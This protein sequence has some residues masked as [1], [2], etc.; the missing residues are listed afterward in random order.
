MYGLGTI[1]PRLF[2][3][4]LVPLHT[5]IFAPEA[6]GV[7]TYLYAFVAF[8]NMVYMWGMET[9]FFRFAT[10]PGADATRIFQLAQTVV[11][12]IS[13]TLSVSL[14]L[15]RN[16]LAELLPLEGHSEYVTWLAAVM[17]MDAVVAI[18]FA[19][20]RLEKK[21]IRFAVAK[22]VNVLLLL[23]FNYYL[24]VFR[25]KPADVGYVFLA[26]A[27]A[28]AV[29]L[30]FFGGTLLSWR[31]AFDRQITPAMFSYAYPVMLTGVAG[32]VN[33]MFSRLTLEWWL[34]DNFYEGQTPAYA[35]GVF[36]A[37]YK[38]AVFM[39]LAV[40]AFRFAAEPFFFSNASNKQ[41]PVLF[42]RVNHFFVI[43]CCII[44]VAVSLNLHILKHILG[45]E[46]YWS[47]L[48]IVPILLIAYLF[49]G[50]YYNFSVWFKL[51]DKTH[52]GTWI[53]LG[54]AGLT[55]VLNYL[56]IPHWG[57]VGSSWAALGCYG[58]MM[59]TCYFF[60]Q[61]YFPIPYR[62]PRSLLYL[63]SAV[64]LILVVPLIPLP[65]GW[66]TTTFP[67]LASLLYVGV[68]YA[69]ERKNLLAASIG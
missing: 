4:L 27:L 57:Y 28:N 14:I 52:F 22:V 44:L 24:L 64:G 18:P 53:T 38:Y 5:K 60:G 17:C 36:G 58:G 49:L 62:I 37:C 66:V 68:I 54:G 10:K 41:S 48:T 69:V 39:N 59:V 42:A 40:Q 34:P 45:D 6:F 9:A 11:T 33:E 50:V 15:F 3:F 47:G 35:L 1:I 30:F 31:P 13:V 55:I 19:K 61:R 8:F 51:S 23:G 12:A 26:N 46:A 25:Q 20:L 2:N 7:V 21:P 16:P 63:A 56:F 43:V 29:Y 67:V 32:M 65:E